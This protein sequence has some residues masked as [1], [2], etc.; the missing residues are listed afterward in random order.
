MAT[1]AAF[2]RGGEVMKRI[3]H[4]LVTRIPGVLAPARFRDN[5]AAGRMLARPPRVRS[6][7]GLP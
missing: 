4:G 1:S 5:R 7:R 3:R 2:G 6:G